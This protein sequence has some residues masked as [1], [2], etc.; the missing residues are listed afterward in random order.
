MSRPE[1]YPVKK[2]LGFDRA[3]LEAVE[4]WRAKQQ[5]IP[6]VS[7]A[8]RQLINIGLLLPPRR[9][10]NGAKARAKGPAAETRKDHK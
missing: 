1:L 4:K 8:I 3:M 7:E 9:D 6:T 2:I 10:H 5:T